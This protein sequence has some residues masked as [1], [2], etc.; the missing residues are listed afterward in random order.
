MNNTE[1]ATL[2]RLAQACCPQQ[3]FDPLTPDAWAGL[4]DDVRF[5]DARDALRAIAKR[6]PFVAPAE[7]RAE[8]GRIRRNRVEAAGVIDPPADLDPDI[9]ANYRAWLKTATAAI[10]DGQEPPARAVGNRTMPAIEGTFHDV[11]EDA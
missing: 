3:K 4:L 10:A 7:I 8:V 11:Q 5:D 6:Q 1:A 2:C 9:E